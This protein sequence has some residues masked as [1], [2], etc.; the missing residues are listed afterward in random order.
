MWLENGG[1]SKGG[2]WLGFHSWEYKACYLSCARGVHG[3]KIKKEELM[4]I[5]KNKA[6]I[7]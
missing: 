5:G 4:L 1:E 7:V 2:N 6:A 3:G